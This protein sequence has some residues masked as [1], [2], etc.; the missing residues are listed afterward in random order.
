MRKAQIIFLASVPL[1][2]AVALRCGCGDASVCGSGNVVSI[3]GP[4]L[5]S[6]SPSVSPAD[7]CS[8]VI[9]LRLSGP[10][11]VTL[12]AT[13]RL[14]ITPVS[15]SGPLEGI[16]DYCNIGRFVVLEAVSPNLRCVGACS[17]FGPQFVAQGV[18]PFSVTARLLGVSA[19]FAGTIK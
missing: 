5:P 14:D 7:P 6:P 9:G 1:L 11:E 16:L 18:G 17:S 2:M 19:T 10:T 15:P 3:S 13:W 4:S 12:G 8:P